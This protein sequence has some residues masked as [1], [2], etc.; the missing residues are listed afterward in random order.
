[1]SRLRRAGRFALAALIALVTA[2]GGDQ[3]ASTE[4]CEPAGGDAT[5]VCM[6]DIEYLPAQVTVPAGDRVVWTNADKVPH[7]VTKES[8]PGPDFDSGTVAARQTYEQSFPA[9]GR[10]DYVCTIHPSQR[11]TVVV[12]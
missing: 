3:Q 2:C 1:L 8:G 10:I 12:E 9:A 7:T 4:R 6:K 11:G 5:P